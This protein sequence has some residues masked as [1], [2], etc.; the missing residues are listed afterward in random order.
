MITKLNRHWQVRFGL[1]FVK[2][3]SAYAAIA[4]VLHALS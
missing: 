4:I 2:F 1:A 3:A